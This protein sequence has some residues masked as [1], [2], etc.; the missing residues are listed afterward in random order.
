MPVLYVLCPQLNYLNPA[1][2][3]IPGYATAAEWSIIVLTHEMWHVTAYTH[4]EWHVSAY[5]SA[6]WHVP[7]LRIFSTLLFP[8][9]MTVKSTACHWFYNLR[10]S[11]YINIPLVVHLKEYIWEWNLFIYEMWRRSEGRF[12][13]QLSEGINKAAESHNSGQESRTSQRRRPSQNILKYFAHEVILTD[14]LRKNE[15][16]TFSFQPIS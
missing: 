12:I 6:E 13:Q 4:E 15:G 7:A 5:R 8:V 1:P 2:N 10:T 16:L 9:F 14:F 11:P 3:K